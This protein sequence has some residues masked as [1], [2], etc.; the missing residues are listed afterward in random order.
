MGANFID[1]HDRFA[2][3]VM[4]RDDAPYFGVVHVCVSLIVV[5]CE[6]ICV[7]KPLKAQRAF[8]KALC[9]SSALW[10]QWALI[11]PRLLLFL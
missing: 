6:V 11:N 2:A 5:M 3:R 8:K 7:L 4:A 10:E 9:E 1:L